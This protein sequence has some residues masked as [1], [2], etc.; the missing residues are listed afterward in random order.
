MHRYAHLHDADNK[1]TPMSPTWRSTN[2]FRSRKLRNVLLVS[3]LVLIVFTSARHRTD[4]SPLLRQL[5][6]KYEHTEFSP[7]VT[8][9]VR[10]S[11]FAYTQYV[12]NENYLCNSLMIF[13]SLHRLKSKADRVMMYPRDWTVPDD[14]GANSTFASKS[15]AQARDQYGV[16]LVPIEVLS[17]KEQEITWADSFTKLLAFNQ[18]QY[19]RV[20]NVDSDSTIVKVRAPYNHLPQNRIPPEF[21]NI[22]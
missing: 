9:D 14:D 19:K 4:I 10:W 1:A 5:Y 13:E 7:F 3:L 11:D 21:G 20:V 17:F 22:F 12:T 16:K 15:L 2:W 18:T 6:D 8:P